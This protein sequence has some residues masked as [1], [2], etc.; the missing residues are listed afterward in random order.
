[1]VVQAAQYL[2]EMRRFLGSTPDPEETY[3]WGWTELKRL[4]APASVDSNVGTSSARGVGRRG[5]N[6]DGSSPSPPL[7]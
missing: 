7:A 1:M 6:A 5:A 2:R 3:A 4:A